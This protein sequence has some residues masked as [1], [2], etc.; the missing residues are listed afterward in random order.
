[1]TEFAA[2]AAGKKAD[3]GNISIDVVSDSEFRPRLADG[4]VVHQGVTDIFGIQTV[5]LVKLLFKREDNCEFVDNPGN[6]SDSP[7]APGPNLRADIIE[8]RNTGFFGGLGKTQIK[9]REVDQ[10]QQVGRLIPFKNLFDPPIGL[11]DG[12]Q[13]AKN[14]HESDHSQLAAGKNDLTAQRRHPFSADPEIFQVWINATTGG[15]QVGPMQIPRILTG[16]DKGLTF[17]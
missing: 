13:V 6:F 17:R 10:N 8:N 4:E 1:M 11:Q 15:N 2:T 7:P 9:F 5:G 3:K 14:F 16:D 12:W